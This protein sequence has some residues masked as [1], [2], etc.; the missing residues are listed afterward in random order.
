[1]SVFSSFLILFLS[2]KL[3][4]S[5][6]KENC[7]K[8]LQFVQKNMIKLCSPFRRAYFVDSRKIFSIS[9]FVRNNSNTSCGGIFLLKEEDVSFQLFNCFWRSISFFF[10]VVNLRFSWNGKHRGISMK[11]KKVERGKG[12]TTISWVKNMNQWYFYVWKYHKN[13]D[14]QHALLAYTIGFIIGDLELKNV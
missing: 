14:T 1:M 9:S 4:V 8:C 11:L 7:N 10:H 6:Y 13:N 12:N 2:W 3:N 5:A